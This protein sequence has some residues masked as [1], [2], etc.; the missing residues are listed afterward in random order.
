MAITS[1]TLQAAIEQFLPRTVNYAYDADTGEKDPEAVFERVMQ[2]LLTA[3]L[4][5]RDAVFYVVYLAAQRLRVQATAVVDLLEALQGP[6]LLRAVR[7]ERPQRITDT[8]KLKKARQYL[9]RLRAR[10]ASG[11]GFSATHYASFR[12]ELL[13]FMSEEVVD[14]LLGRNRVILEAELKS[15][16]DEIRDAWSELLTSRDALFEITSD[17]QAVDLKSKVSLLIADLA[18]EKLSALQDELESYTAAEQAESAED[19][20]LVGTASKSALATV[21]DAPSPFGTT[22]HGPAE[23][24]HTDRTYLE[25]IGVLRPEPVAFRARGRAGKLY[26][27]TLLASTTG[28]LVDDVDGD[29]L[30]P[31]LEDTEV[32][33]TSVASVGMFVTFAKVGRSHRVTAVTATQLTLSP[34]VP[35]AISDARYVLTEKVP[36]SYFRDESGT[37]DIVGGTAASFWRTGTGSTGS[38]TIASGTAGEF[39][40]SAL[41]EASDGSNAKDAGVAGE[42]RPAKA[43]SATGVV[44]ELLASGTSDAIYVG[45]DHLDD[46]SADF[47]GDGIE[48]GMLLEV[49]AHFTLGGTYEVTSVATT[50]VDVT[51]SFDD[52]E[53]SGVS[54]E[55]RRADDVLVD[56]NATF[57]SDG[58]EAG[59]VVV[60]ASGALAGSYTVA[61]VES[62]T[63]L[64]VASPFGATAETAVSYRVERADAAYVFTDA[65]ASFVSEG[66]ETGD[67]ITVA[68]T[69]YVVDAVEGA[70]TLTVT[71]PFPS[72]STGNA[73]VVPLPDGT[74]RSDSAYLQSAGVGAGDVLSVTATGGTYPVTSVSDQHHLLVSGSF[75]ASAGFTGSAWEVYA[76]D[77]DGDRTSD[78]FRVDAGTDLTGWGST[79][80]GRRVVLTIGG[81]EYVLLSVHDAGLY[82]LRVSPVAK[83]ASGLTWS[84]AYEG[85]STT[86]T[87]ATATFTSTAARGD[88]LVLRPGTEDEERAVV[89]EVVSDTELSLN[90]A[91]TADL[92]DVEYALLHDVRPG[93]ELHAGGRTVT[94]VDVVNGTTLQVNPPLPGVIGR[95]VAYLVTAKGYGP[96]VRRLVDDDA[97]FDE[98]LV[99]A[100]IDLA[101]EPPA[102]GTILRVVDATTIDVS[103]TARLGRRDVPYRI[104]SAPPATTNEFMFDAATDPGMAA[105]DVLTIWEQDGTITVVSATAAGATITATVLETLPST[106]ED[107]HF[108]V[109]RGGSPQHGRYLLLEHENEALTFSENTAQLRLHVAEVLSDFGADV[110]DAEFSLTGAAGRAVDDQDDDSR[111]GAF[112]D[113]TAD[114]VAGGA[115]V[116]DRLTVDGRTAYVSEVVSATRLVV[117]PEL[118][119]TLSGEAW[120]LDRNSVSFAI[121]EA[122]RLQAEVEALIEVLDAFVVPVNTTVHDALE[123][124]KQHG[125]DRAVDSLLSGDVSTFLTLESSSSASF[126][127]AAKS[128]VQSA[129]QSVSSSTSTAASTASLD[130]AT[131]ETESDETDTQV[132]LAASSRTLAGAE[133]TS[134]V[135]QLS[136]DELKNRAIYSLTGEVESGVATDDD[137][138]LPWIAET[139]SKKDRLTAEREAALAA[140][141]Y[142]L[143]HPEEFVAEDS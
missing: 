74:F 64:T 138:T 39:V 58:V 75:G 93:M 45:D 103:V 9:S 47:V 123:I 37:I 130:G 11:G 65:A 105:D 52:T 110:E 91:V 121:Y 21:A 126:S 73:W 78:L 80:G 41:A 25:R 31:T 13:E 40:A 71:T 28:T 112:E 10:L 100:E 118:P 38:T 16:L 114:F 18:E 36:G 49:L 99:G 34:E 83:V 129:G 5:D 57:L 113:A 120:T 97:V 79:M 87:D 72:A 143:A 42:T 23:D 84:L 107:E 46:S 62:E 102:T 109:V 131:A 124:L 137:P 35:L 94:V 17:F 12:D 2:V 54:Y 14:K 142:I 132:A 128:A 141:D 115:R 96:N 61:S 108:V 32:D 48:V 3:L 81:T 134:T 59:D 66:V 95:D 44:Q 86:F 27:G 136:Q 88:V 60:I 90:S 117:R 1:E 7:P 70:V 53:T 98:A 127:G 29:A 111:T 140:L 104:R 69:D 43:E 85:G 89:S 4:L 30:T 106:L 56:P 22:I 20:L 77:G 135:A 139:G 15:S 67:T 133:R 92:V 125:M 33:F 119:V 82:E 19:I 6:T 26:L 122:S 68:G 76:V 51:P 8:S 101:T 50:S 116:G 63:Q 55:I 24:G